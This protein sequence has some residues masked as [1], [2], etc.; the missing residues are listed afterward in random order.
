MDMGTQGPRALSRS[1]GHSR[2]AVVTWLLHRPSSHTRG[3]QQPL[4]RQGRRGW[5]QGAARSCPR[6]WNLGW[7][8]VAL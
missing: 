2:A 1:L 3:R 8:L 6:P 7:A 4:Q 5:T